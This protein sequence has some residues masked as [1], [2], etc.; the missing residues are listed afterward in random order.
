MFYARNW[1]D[2]LQRDLKA[3]T[4]SRLAGIWIGNTIIFGIG[5]FFNIILK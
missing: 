1:D 3:F 4:F 5:K 2:F